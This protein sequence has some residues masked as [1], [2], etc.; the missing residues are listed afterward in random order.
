VVGETDGAVRELNERAEPQFPRTAHLAQVPGAS[1]LPEEP[2]AKVLVA[3]LARDW[4]VLGSAGPG[5]RRSDTEPVD[6]ATYTLS[7]EQLHSRP[8]A[9]LP[10]VRGRHHH[11]FE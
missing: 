6:R 3:E 5:S 8:H 7:G 2:E 1:V 9:N 10:V 11:R 4:F